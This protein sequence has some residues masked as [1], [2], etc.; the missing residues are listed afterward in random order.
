MDRLLVRKAITILL[1][2]I[3]TT[4]ELQAQ[5]N[6]F[7]PVPNI[8]SPDAATLGK[9]GT[10]NVNYY[11]GVPEISIPLH[12]INEN[13]LNIPIALS[14]DASGFVPNKNAGV[15]GLNWS[16]IAGGAITRVVNGVPDD[17]NNPNAEISNTNFGYIY[18][19]QSGKGTYSAEHIRTIGFISDINNPI[20]NLN[21]EYIPDVFSFNFL[22]HSGKFFM[23]NTGKVQVTGDRNYKVDLKDLKPQYDFLTTI[24]AVTTT[25]NS[26]NDSLYS[27]IVITSDDGYTF[28]FG[29]SFKT[30]EI[31][32]AS[33]QI[34]GRPDRKGGQINAWYL[35]KAV[36]PDGNEIL[37]N[38]QNYSTSDYNYI[39][40]LF[41]S[42]VGQDTPAGFM[43][44]KL[45]RNHSIN[46][47]Q[48]NGN[49]V[50]SE[51]T[52]DIVYLS[53]IK[54]AY[55]TEIVTRLQKVEFSY[56]EKDLNTKFYGNPSDIIA[57]NTTLG[58]VIRNMYTQRLASINF[59]SLDQY[60]TYKQDRVLYLFYEYYGNRMFLK[61][62]QRNR[63]LPF[64]ANYPD[65]DKFVF[66]YKNTGS[67]PSALTRGIDLW[68]YYNGRNGN[69][70]LVLAPAASSTEYESDPSNPSAY[71]L[72]DTNYVSY[73]MLHTITYPTGGVTQFT[74]EG[75]TYSKALKR[76]VSSGITPVW[77]QVNGIA[78]GARIREIKNT[79]GT[80]TTFK[81]INSYNQNPNNPSSGLLTTS[82]VYYL[83]YISNN[84]RMI[85]LSDNN[86]ATA[87]NYK[88][89]HIAYKEVVEINGEGY[90]R[91]LFTNP[92]TNADT[93]FLGNDS[94]KV[95]PEVSTTNFNQQ[96]MRL[97]RY[98]SRE[99]ER[100]LPLTTEVYDNANNLRKSTAYQYNTDA[101]KDTAR[102][103][104]QYCTFSFYNLSGKMITLIQ[105]YAM[106]HYHNLVTR[107]VEKDF[108]ASP[109]NPVT[110]TN[111]FKYK[112]NTSRL[113]IEKSDI[114]SMG[115]TMVFKFK[116]PVDF[117]G[118]EPYT[119]MINRHQLSYLV[120][121]QQYK[122]VQ[123]PV[124]LRSSKTNFGFWQS[125]TLIK[126]ISME[127]K[128]GAANAEVRKQFTGYDNKGNLMLYSNETGGAKFQTSFI[129][130]YIQTLPIA[131]VENA[132]STEIAYTSFDTEGTG[133]WIYAASRGSS[134]TAR[135]GTYYFLLT[136]SNNITRSGLSPGNKYIVSYWTRNAAAYAIA[137][138]TGT[139]QGKTINGWT[140]FE[141]TITGQSSVAITGTGAI[142][143]LRLYPANAAMTSYLY[144]GKANMIVQTDPSGNSIFYDYDGE[145]RLVMIRDQDNNIVKR[146]CYNYLGKEEICGPLFYK[147][148]AI[149][150]NFTKGD[151]PGGVPGS[152]VSYLVPAG[153]HISIISQADADQK[154]TA[155]LQANGQHYADSIGTCTPQPI[156]IT[157]INEFTTSTIPSSTVELLQNGS[158]MYTQAFPA[159]NNS[160]VSFSVLPGVYQLRF[161]V[162]AAYTNTFVV[163]GIVGLQGWSK[164][165]GQTSVTTG[166]VTLNPGTN[167]TISANDGL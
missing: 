114:N 93:Y 135:T 161:K 14:Y 104:G 77:D 34:P 130:G 96:L 10:Y 95:S 100:G 136:G 41:D 36:S 9:Y 18:G 68:G 76:K 106:Y 151:C 112:S 64:P 122:G 62:I 57:G 92:E 54:H 89:S 165:V 7:N 132:D 71:R 128:I 157:L 88:E 72:S 38:Y 110:H 56:A 13:G 78:G 83:D 16:L 59:T 166:N 51:N 118:A 113:Q 60:G 119:T 6:S 73:G 159:S 31:G 107:I 24:A 167:Y 105:S 143:E 87:G 142:D 43:E 129:W 86:I 69:T 109:A 85:R 12:S 144:N 156:Q 154:A 111:N 21:Y 29:G 116:F 117:A 45:F 90:T 70:D 49:T 84:E 48:Q 61:E 140:Y 94:Y 19:Q 30:L 133:N 153:K 101:N 65:Y 46:I 40:S 147:N 155:D 52:R 3:I 126:P 131:K 162:T 141:H 37:F 138:T 149:S 66:T 80:T 32:F 1:L 145:G 42:Q 123:Q 146:I 47:V 124:F 98:S 139:V 121:Q 91:H 115:D 125:N 67:L 35:T 82:G 148:A 163:Y 97:Y 4:I 17:K 2:A 27:R 33:T 50:V 164:P 63:G 5:Q 81:Y 26:L 160:S 25:V 58:S 79:P 158:V 137:G 22:G 39:K 15:A 74:F 44:L 55:L 8:M 127:E 28:Y 152:V 102:S 20:Y 99:D 150:A 103:I 108:G 134:E 120:E 23:D 75:N 11:T 53:L